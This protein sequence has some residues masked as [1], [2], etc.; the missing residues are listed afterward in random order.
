MPAFLGQSSWY[1]VVRWGVKIYGGDHVGHSK[2]IC[3]WVER[4]M[5]DFVY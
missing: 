5:A 3:E 4:K 1:A 2:A